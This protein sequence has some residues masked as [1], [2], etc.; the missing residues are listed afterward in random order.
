[1]FLSENQQVR[2]DRARGKGRSIILRV[3]TVDQ[4]GYS[5][6]DVIVTENDY[7][8]IVRARKHNAGSDVEILPGK[9]EAAESHESKPKPKS[10][11][12][13]K[14]AQVDEQEGD[15]LLAI[16]ASLAIGKLV[17]E[18]GEDVIDFVQKEGRKLIAGKK[19]KKPTKELTQEEIKAAQEGL[20]KWK[21]M[22]EKKGMK[23][24]EGGILYP[25]GNIP[26]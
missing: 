10:K 18:Y 20:K 7:N 22:T 16:A 23:D 13:G 26:E 5:Q 19:K 9:I 11:G 15:G 21:K 14:A 24:Q 3:K 2:L 4:D 25:M 12:K 17:D 1:M 8:K 6:R